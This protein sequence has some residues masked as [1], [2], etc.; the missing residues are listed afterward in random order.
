MIAIGSDHCGYEL[1]KKIEAYLDQR[2]I[3]YKDFGCRQRPVLSISCLRSSR[4]PGRGKR[5]VR[6]RTA[7]LAGTGVDLGRVVAQWQK[8]EA[9]EYN[10][11]T[12]YPE[13]AATYSW[14]DPS[15][16]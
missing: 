1:K 5:R 14:I 7:V 12:V 9:G 13:G 8:N 16:K 3:P 11:V 10:L 4:C 15:D 2:K 6:P